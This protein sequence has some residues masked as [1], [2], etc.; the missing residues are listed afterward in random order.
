MG[1]EKPCGGKEGMGGADPQ[2]GTHPAT[3]GHTGR[4]LKRVVSQ[5]L[6]RERQAALPATGPGGGEGGWTLRRQLGSWPG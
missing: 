4:F 3:T 1:E 6:P 5:M 2:Q